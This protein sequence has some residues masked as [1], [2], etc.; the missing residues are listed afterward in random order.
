M[1]WS[2]LLSQ[3]VLYRV[4]CGDQRHEGLYLG[5]APALAYGSSRGSDQGTTLRASDLHNALTAI[6]NPFN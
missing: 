4:H 3:S 2:W 5:S 6:L 1:E